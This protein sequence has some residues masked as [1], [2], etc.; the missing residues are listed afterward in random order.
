VTSRDRHT[1]KQDIA[2]ELAGKVEIIAQL[3][4]QLATRDATIANLQHSITMERCSGH[5][6]KEHPCI[7]CVERLLAQQKADA[8]KKAETSRIEKKAA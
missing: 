3:R 4:A 2:A 8:A 5:C 6:T 7:G 1:R